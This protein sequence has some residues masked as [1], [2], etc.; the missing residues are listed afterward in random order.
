MRLRSFIPTTITTAHETV[1][2]L[3]KNE[4]MLSVQSALDNKGRLVSWAVDLGLE[5][6]IKNGHWPFDYRWV[7]YARP[8]GHYLEIRTSHAVL[9]VSQVE[10][11]TMQPRDVKFR[12][13]L[14]YSQQIPL[15]LSELSADL[16]IIGVPHILLV[17]G[18]QQPR[19]AHLGLPNA[20]HDMGYIYRTPNLMNMPHEVPAPMPPVEQTDIEAVVTLKEEIEKWRRDHGG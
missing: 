18:H 3:V 6:L 20:R 15:P 5:K 11:P 10:E 4:Q 13:N 8:T 1:S 19:F 9:T 14:R 17:H 12:A 2:L 7:P 16:E